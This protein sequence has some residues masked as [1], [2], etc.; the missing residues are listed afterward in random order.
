VI[1]C[2]FIL[3]CHV[4][5]DIGQEVGFEAVGIV[6]SKLPT[7]GVWARKSDEV[8]Y[9]YILVKIEATDIIVLISSPS[10]LSDCGS[11]IGRLLKGGGL[12][13]QH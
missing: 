2:Y 5:S 6:D 4:R 13:P 7:T 10:F 8:R 11:S 12:L 9:M 1:L 3:L